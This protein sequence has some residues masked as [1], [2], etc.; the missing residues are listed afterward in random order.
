MACFGWPITG[1]S[2][3]GTSPK[4]LSSTLR[5][6]ETS[7]TSSGGGSRGRSDDEGVYEEDLPASVAPAIRRCGIS[8]RLTIRARPWTSFPERDLQGMRG[9]LGGR[10]AQDVEHHEVAMGVRDSMLIADLPGIGALTRTSGV[11]SA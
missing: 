7:R 4:W 3:C 8:A 2:R 5:I 11:A 10:R 1:D 6:H 9:L